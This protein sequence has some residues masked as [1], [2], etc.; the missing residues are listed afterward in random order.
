MLPLIQGLGFV[1]VILPPPLRPARA[2]A[3]HES[4]SPT[5]AR[6]A[7]LHAG[8]PHAGRANVFDLCERGAGIN[9]SC[10]AITAGPLDLD[11]RR[12]D[13]AKVIAF[14]V[15]KPTHHTAGHG[16]RAATLCAFEAGLAVLVGVAITLARA[17]LAD[18]RTAAGAFAD[19]FACHD[20]VVRWACME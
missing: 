12:R 1:N 19:Q 13:V 3:Q 7:A 2:F 10:S 5:A 20:D 18:W 15:T 9:Y 16:F 14:D 8:A 4:P 6:V 17:A 11:V